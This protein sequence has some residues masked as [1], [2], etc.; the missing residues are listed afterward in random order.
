MHGMLFTP[1]TMFFKL[2]FAF[3]ELFVFAGPVVNALALT[4]G[5]FYKIILRHS[6]LPES[7]INIA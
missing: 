5:Q 3:N 4:A 6:G 1:F 2:N 7:P